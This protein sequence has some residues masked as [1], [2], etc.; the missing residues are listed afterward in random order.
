MNSPMTL[1][2]PFTHKVKEFD[3]GIEA[4]GLRKL[5]NVEIPDYFYNRKPFGIPIINR[6]INGDGVMKSQ[7]LSVSAPRG[8]GK[9]TFLMMALQSLIDA[10]TGMRCAYLSNEE[11]IEQLAFTATRIGASSIMADNVCDI[12]DI[13]ELMTNLDVVVIDSFPGLRSKNHNTPKA[14]EQYAINKLIKQAKATG[15]VLFF[16]MHFTKDGKEAGSKNLYHAVDT[17]MT[18]TKMDAEDYGDNCRKIETTKNRFGELTDVILRMTSRGFDFLNPVSENVNDNASPK[19][20]GVYIEAR[21]RDTNAIIDVVTKYNTE[22]G[23]KVQHFNE[24]DIDVSRVGRLLK[25]MVDNGAIL[26][27]GGGKGQSRDTKRWY[28]GSLTEEDDVF[29]EVAED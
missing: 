5:C 10:N 4:Q 8:G 14:L 12:D 21:K 11:C 23:A 28:L 3:L 1:V 19:G 18:V 25:G 22:G 16:V 24:L 15:C 7:V 29:N 13:A 26:A 6:L 2:S 9:T 27:T 17:C 20:T